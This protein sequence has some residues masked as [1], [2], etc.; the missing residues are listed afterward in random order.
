[1]NK[2]IQFMPDAA[3]DNCGHFGA[4]DLGDQHLC[5]D[6]YME[7]GS[8][9]LEFGEHDLWKN[10]DKQGEAGKKSQPVHSKNRKEE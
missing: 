2:P 3:C 6:C 10:E 4:Y 9:C 8:C 7:C 5:S 1:M